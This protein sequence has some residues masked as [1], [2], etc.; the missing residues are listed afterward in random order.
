MSVDGS[1][2]AP[3]ARGL[4]SIPADDAEPSL[5]AALNAVEGS[6]RSISLEAALYGTVLY[7]F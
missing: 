5:P 6:G 4:K 2:K 1:R 7:S 3:S